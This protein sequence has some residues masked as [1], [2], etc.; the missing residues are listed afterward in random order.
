M[1]WWCVNP[2]GRFSNKKQLKWAIFVAI[3]TMSTG[4]QPI[5]AYF[6]LPVKLDNVVA[7]SVKSSVYFKPYSGNS[8]VSEPKLSAKAAI[9]A[10]NQ[11]QASLAR[12]QR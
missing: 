7:W 3:S 12:S 9:L 1:M 6:R 2:L 11:F 5:L 8:G 10:Y 4:Y